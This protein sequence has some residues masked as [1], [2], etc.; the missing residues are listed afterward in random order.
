MRTTR[1]KD[2]RDMRMNLG[3]F[4][5]EYYKKFGEENYEKFLE[6]LGPSLVDQYGEAFSSENMRIMEAEFVTF[7][8]V[9]KD[10]KKDE[11]A[12]RDVTSV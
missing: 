12:S 9:L 1:T 4:L 7:S 11:S 8:S 2:I 10:K 5:H 3:K 6:K